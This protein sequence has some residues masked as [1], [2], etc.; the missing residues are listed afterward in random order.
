MV[1]AAIIGVDGR[2]LAARRAYPS[3]SAG[4]WE[5]PGGK[6]EPGETDHQALIRE[7]HEELSVIVEPGKRLG[8]DIVLGGGSAVLRVWLATISAGTP[9]LVDHTELRWL[10]HDELCTV[11]WLPA[12]APL[13]TQL[14][15]HLSQ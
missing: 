7:C 14:R 2:V 5:F 4:M 1:A 8:T 13:V 12:D 6:V 9:Q 15:S 3:R 11:N 10:A